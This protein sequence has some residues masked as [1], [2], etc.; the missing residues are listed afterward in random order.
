MSAARE[1]LAESLPALT[2]DEARQTLEFVHALR[3]RTE[4]A[5][6]RRR[7]AGKPGYRLPSPDHAGFPPVEPARTTGTPASELLIRDRR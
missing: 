6:L 1:S 5:E 3:R 4:L 2:E 7:L